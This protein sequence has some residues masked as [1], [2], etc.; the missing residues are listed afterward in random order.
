MTPAANARPVLVSPRALKVGEIV[1]QY[2]ILAPLGG[3]GM[4]AVYKVRRGEGIFVLKILT[5]YFFDGVGASGKQREQHMRAVSEFLPAR[6]LAHPNIVRQL[7]FDVWPDLTSGY[8][9]IV[10]EYVD[11][12]DICSWRV[13]AAPSLRRICGVL[14]QVADALGHMH[15]QGFI[16]RDLKDANLLVR[17]GKD[18]AVVI[19]LGVARHEA[20]PPVTEQAAIIGTKTHYAPEYVRWFESPAVRSEPFK[21]TPSVDLY[22]LGYVAYEV[23]TGSPPVTWSGGTEVLLAAIRNDPAVDPRDLN[24]AIPEPLAALVVQ[25]LEKDPAA[26]PESALKVREVLDGI[27]ATAGPPYDEEPFPVP[28]PRENAAGTVAQVLPG[29]WMPTWCRQQMEAAAEEQGPVIGSARDEPSRGED[30]D[31]RGTDG[32]GC[33]TSASEAAA[34]S[35]AQAAAKTAISSAIRKGRERLAAAAPR[36]HLTGRVLGVGALGV[37]G[38]VLVGFMLASGKRSPEKDDL[39]ARLQRE[40]AAAAKGGGT[41]KGSTATAP[42]I[43]LELRTVPGLAPRLSTPDASAPSTSDARNIDAALAARYGRPTVPAADGAAAEGGASTTP[44]AT[45][46]ARVGSEAAEAHVQASPGDRLPNAG[47]DRKIVKAVHARAPVNAD[48]FF[49]GE[50]LDGAPRSTS[51]GDGPRR[52]GIAMGTHIRARLQ[53]N[54]D[55]RTIGAGVVEAVLTQPLILRGEIALPARTML[56]GQARENVGRFNID[57]TRLRLPD[58]TEVDFHGV[59]IDLNDNK[60]GLAASARVTPPG[61]QGEGVGARIAR[62]TGNTVLNTVTGGLVEDVARGAGSTIVSNPASSSA[63]GADVPAIL[64][65]GGVQ[66]EVFVTKTF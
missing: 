42:Q 27:L 4:G 14:R 28:P 51:S 33:P 22:A 34:A 58:D 30:L 21:W 46:P 41:A 57:F 53:S 10:M 59:A 1:G 20:L 29:K 25:L 32:A 26:R 35:P 40:Q 61:Y 19:D 3:G 60:P 6:V 49:Y 44:A 36:L 39:L 23:L 66:F 7:S 15:A 17:R 62:Q 56:Y 5:S 37:A 63:G 52:F 45:A 43:P 11:G 31:A 12:R 64:L 55:S 50:S 65:E 38:C 2:E 24:P 16:H 54:L 47:S 18:E 13:E 8:P 9:Y 48:P